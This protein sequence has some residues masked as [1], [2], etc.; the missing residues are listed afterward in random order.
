MSDTLDAIF[1]ELNIKEKGV[2]ASFS[3]EGEDFWITKS[4]GLFR[5][6]TIARALIEVCETDRLSVI[7]G[8]YDHLID[9]LL[10]VTAYVPKE[11]EPVMLTRADYDEVMQTLSKEDGLKAMNIH[12]DIPYGMAVACL[13]KP[14]M[15]EMIPELVDSTSE[16]S[17]EDSEES[18]KKIQQVEDSEK[19]LDSPAPSFRVEAKRTGKSQN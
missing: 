3:I 11:G 19:T 10:A 8:A 16:N 6:Q 17:V 1:R 5:L 9:P 13:G 15:A 12:S 14:I 4:R 7:A 18:S 2:K